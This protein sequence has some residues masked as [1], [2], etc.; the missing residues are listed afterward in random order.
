MSIV[1]EKMD[2]SGNLPWE[3]LLDADPSEEAISIYIKRSEIFAAMFDEEI[4]GVLAVMETR[5]AIWEI[6]NIA[7][8]EGWKNRGIGKR[9][10]MKA[11]DMA[12]SRGA[13]TIELGTGNSSIDQLAFYQKCG[14]RISGIDSGYFKRHYKQPIVENGIPCVD[15]IRLAIHF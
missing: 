15:M 12:K 13:A 9:L 1:I 7:V 11:I 6:M 14:F 2:S 10:V 8:K 4:C 5:P 3:L